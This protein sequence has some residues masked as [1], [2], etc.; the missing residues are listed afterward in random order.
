MLQKRR[1]T[2]RPGR[3]QVDDESE[4]GKVKKDFIITGYKPAYGK[5][6]NDFIQLCD[7][8]TD[9]AFVGFKETV[10]VTFKE[11]A[12]ET[13]IEKASDV[14]KR[15]YESLGCRNINVNDGEMK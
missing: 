11:T 7:L 4:G 1:E 12:T 6:V 15:G 14:L 9:G 3:W 8:G 10:T 13:Q 2:D 5:E